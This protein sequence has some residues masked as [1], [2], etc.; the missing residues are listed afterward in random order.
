MDVFELYDLVLDFYVSFMVFL[1]P[2][3]LISIVDTDF[4][5]FCVLSSFSK[6]LTCFFGSLYEILDVFLKINTF[7]R[8]FRFFSVHWRFV[9]IFWEFMWMF[10][11]F[12]NF[13]GF[14]DLF[15]PYG[16]FLF[17][18][19]FDVSFSLFLVLWRFIS[20]LYKDFF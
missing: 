3:S 18:F 7:F 11:I 15:G 13:W 4:F 16:M 10:M 19:D 5:D 6:I 17:S 9:L 1:A 2:S 14:L 8:L 20:I 12:M